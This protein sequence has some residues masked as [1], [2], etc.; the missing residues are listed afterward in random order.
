MDEKGNKDWIEKEIDQL[1]SNVTR[2]LILIIIRDS[3]NSEPIHGYGLSEKI[4]TLS[5][6]NIDVTNA[7]FYAI[8]RQLKNDKFIEQYELPDDVRK[9]YKLTESG[10]EGLKRLLNYWDKYYDF[11][12]TL[13]W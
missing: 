11:I 13:M 5:Y 9:Y 8:L 10:E 12:K 6:G 2:V 1:K 3:K 4:V 7:T